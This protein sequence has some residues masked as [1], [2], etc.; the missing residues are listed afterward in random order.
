MA[1]KVTD[2]HDKIFQRLKNAAEGN[3]T[4]LLDNQSYT[5]R[6]KLRPDLILANNKKSEALIIDVTMSF[7]DSVESFRDKRIHK[8]KKYSPV[9]EQLSKKYKK[10]T[11][12]AFIVGPLGA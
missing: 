10:I 7:E 2:R 11:F 6:D 4:V 3:W 8:I 5:S 1:T 12:E 9:A